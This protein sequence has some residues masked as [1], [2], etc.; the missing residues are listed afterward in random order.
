MVAIWK[1]WNYTTCHHWDQHCDHQ[2]TTP[3]HMYHILQYYRMVMA[4]SKFYHA[5]S[6]PDD[7]LP[8]IPWSFSHVTTHT[9]SHK[10]FFAHPIFSL[11][12]L[13]CF[14][15][16]ARVVGWKTE[17]PFGYYAVPS[18]NCVCMAV[19]IIY[20]TVIIQRHPDIISR[21]SCRQ[22][23]YNISNILMIKND[24]F[25][26]YILKRLMSNSVMPYWYKF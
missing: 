21:C 15:K 6:S 26:N 23:K 11:Y 3:S 22:W 4:A 9:Y 20:V 5:D 7:V 24:K 17:V 14:C 10:R 18:I 16:K 12:C 2:E 19:V 8:S 25:A 1:H 13:W